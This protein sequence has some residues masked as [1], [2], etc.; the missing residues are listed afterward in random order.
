MRSY[1]EE[2][3]QYIDTPWYSRA[4]WMYDLAQQGLSS[5]QQILFDVQPAAYV[6]EYEAR[7]ILHA[8]QRGWPILNAEA[9]RSSVDRVRASTLDFLHAPFADLVED[10]WFSSTGIEAFIRAWYI[11]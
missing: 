7:Y 11:E 2:K 10:G 8:I 4:N 9:Q 6:I 3:E 1:D 5:K